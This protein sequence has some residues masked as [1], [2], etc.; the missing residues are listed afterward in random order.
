MCMLSCKEE[1]TN[2]RCLP[3]CTVN[4]YESCLN[5]HKLRDV[6]ADCVSTNS[7]AILKILR[8][9]ILKINPH[10]TAV[11]TCINPPVLLGRPRVCVTTLMQ[12]AVSLRSEALLTSYKGSLWA[13]PSFI[14]L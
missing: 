7:G 4:P 10:N 5:M 6:S 14:F 12:F 8:G 1:V 11:L 2:T 9:T 3:A 13:P